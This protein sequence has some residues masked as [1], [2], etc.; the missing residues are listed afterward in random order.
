M[1]NIHIRSVFEITILFSFLKCIRNYDNENNLYK[2][3]RNAIQSSMRYCFTVDCQQKQS[4]A[5]VIL[6]IITVAYKARS[7]NIDRQTKTV[8][9]TVSDCEW[10]SMTTETTNNVRIAVFC[11]YC[12]CRSQT[13]YKHCELFVFHFILFQ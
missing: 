5:T 11:D 12:C 8:E 6:R 3:I 13:K 1:S 7:N 4:K 2:I 10:L 9:M